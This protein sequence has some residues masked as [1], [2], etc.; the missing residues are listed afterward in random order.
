MASSSD[1]H[2]TPSGSALVSAEMVINCAAPARISAPRRHAQLGGAGTGTGRVDVAVIAAA[3]VSAGAFCVVM[4]RSWWTNSRVTN[5]VPTRLPGAP[6][7]QH[8]PASL[9]CQVTAGQPP[10]LSTPDENSGDE[11]KGE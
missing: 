3:E 1:A 9:G 6:V 10:A 8:N 11:G 4:A 7:Q 5:I 2:V